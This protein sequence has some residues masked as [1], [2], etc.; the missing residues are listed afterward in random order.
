MLLLTN[1]QAALNDT[2]AAK[3]VKSYD[4]YHSLYGGTMGQ[5]QRLIAPSTAGGVS[6]IGARVEQVASQPTGQYTPPDEQRQLQL[7][8]IETNVREFG[9][10]PGELRVATVVG[11]GWAEV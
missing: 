7:V 5:I 6:A 10:Y 8:P 2:P 9:S 1:V 4:L 3:L 11:W